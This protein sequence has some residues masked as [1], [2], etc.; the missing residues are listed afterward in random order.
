MLSG[1]LKMMTTQMPQSRVKMT[2]G[3]TTTARPASSSV[4][5]LARITHSTVIRT[6]A[7]REEGDKKERRLLIMVVAS[8]K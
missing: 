2:Q 1:C 5:Q 8:C 7:G 6:A 3:T 4:R